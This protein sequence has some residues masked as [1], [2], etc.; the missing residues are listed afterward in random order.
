MVSIYLFALNTNSRVPLMILSMDLI[1]ATQ[2]LEVMPWK[3]TKYF[4]KIASQDPMLNIPTHASAP[5]NKVDHLFSH[6]LKVSVNVYEPG[7]HISSGKQYASF[8]SRHEDKDWVTFKRAGDGFLIDSVCEY[9]YT[10][11]SYPRNV[12]PPKKY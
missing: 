2:Y 11:S 7:E 9:G 3:D 5:N 1:Y 10:I 8:Q 6:L 4:Q 12:Q